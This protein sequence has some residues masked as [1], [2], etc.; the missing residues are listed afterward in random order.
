MRGD[1]HTSTP[2]R[3]ANPGRCG[4]GSGLISAKANR[5]GQQHVDVHDQRGHRRRHVRPVQQ[6]QPAHVEQRGGGGMSEY[7]QWSGAEQPAQ[8]AG[9]FPRQGT[10]RQRHRCRRHEQHGGEHPEE[11]VA[12]HVQPQ[13]VAAERE[14]DGPGD[15]RRDPTSHRAVRHLGHVVDRRH[16]RRVAARYTTATAASTVACNSASTSA[17]GSWWVTPA[18]GRPGS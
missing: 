6:P 15:R 5:Y 7:R 8:D 18:A 1:G 9:T 4:A 2:V 10:K 17:A 12:G 11:Q 3:T 16:S 13:V 14:H